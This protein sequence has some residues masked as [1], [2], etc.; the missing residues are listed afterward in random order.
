MGQVWLPRPSCLSIL[1]YARYGTE[2]ILQMNL[3]GPS[4]R[5]QCMDTIVPL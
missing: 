4:S 2:Y 1:Q 5:S 3:S